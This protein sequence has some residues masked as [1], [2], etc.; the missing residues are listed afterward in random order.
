MDNSPLGGRAGGGDILPATGS[1]MQLFVWM[2]DDMHGHA[3]DS[4]Q[5]VNFRRIHNKVSTF[6]Q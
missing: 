2:V 5:G 4:Q 1:A 6:A 3:N